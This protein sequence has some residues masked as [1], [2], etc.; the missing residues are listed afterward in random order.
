M[1]AARDKPLGA[2]DS[3]LRLPSLGARFADRVHRFF[4]SYDV[5]AL[6]TSQVPPFDVELDWPR[7]VAGVPMETY[8]DWM[9]SCCDISLTGCPAIS[10]PSG[11]THDDLPV[12]VQFVGRPRG[13]VDLLRFARVW[14]RVSAAS[15]RRATVAAT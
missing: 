10:M 9:R 8:I 12:G 3:E 1:A 5:L 2:A 11:F 14:E 4:E 15:A 7:H 13:D 6:P